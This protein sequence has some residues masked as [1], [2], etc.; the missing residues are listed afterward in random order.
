MPFRY[1][2]LPQIRKGLLGLSQNGLARELGITPQTVHNWE[3]NLSTPT[4]ETLD[5][6]H[7]ICLGRGL[8]APALWTP[9]DASCEGQTRI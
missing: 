6:I 4:I 5:Q 9:P 7:R 2:R 8:T 1:D 3:R